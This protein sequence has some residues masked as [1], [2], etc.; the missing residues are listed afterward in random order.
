MTLIS[1]V[2]CSLRN[3]CAWCH[4]SKENRRVPNS[5]GESYQDY[6]EKPFS[7]SELYL[8]SIKWDMICQRVK[9]RTWKMLWPS[10]GP[11][12]ISQNLGVS[13]IPWEKQGTELET[14]WNCTPN[15]LQEGCL[16]W[17]Q[18]ITEISVCPACSVVLLPSEVWLLHAVKG[19]VY[20]S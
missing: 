4:R 8:P 20:W 6:Q 15:S 13:L 14:C 5:Q 19:A 18:Q 3:T 16:P 10:L 1:F 17:R 9:S 11:G 2:S 12:A 7:L